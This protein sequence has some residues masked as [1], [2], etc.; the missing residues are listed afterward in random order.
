MVHYLAFHNFF[1]LAYILCNNILIPSS[2]PPRTV[3]YQTTGGE[4][5][6]KRLCKVQAENA[7][8]KGCVR[9]VGVCGATYVLILSSSYT[10]CVVTVKWQPL[11]QATKSQSSWRRLEELQVKDESS[12]SWYEQDWYTP[13]VSCVQL[14]HILALSPQVTVLQC[15]DIC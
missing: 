5:L 8:G 9:Y 13:L 1:S 10:L 2:S 4:C 3:A 11:L 14:I 6:G 15:M 12:T 7:W